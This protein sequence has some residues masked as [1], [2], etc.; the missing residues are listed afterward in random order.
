MTVDTNETFSTVF[1]K[2]IMRPQVK[3]STKLVL[4]LLLLGVL[5][6]EAAAQKSLRRK[7]AQSLN[8]GFVS[9]NTQE[10]L[11]LPDAINR[12]NSADE[13]A[14]LRRIN[15]FSCVVGTRIRTLRALG[16]WSDGAEY[17]VMLRVYSDV[18]TVRYLLS[19]VGREAHQKSVLYFHPA[20]TGGAR[21]YALRP[22]RNNSNLTNVASIM[23]RSGIAFRT[24]VPVKKTTIIFVVDL[25]GELRAK[26]LTAARKLGATVSSEKGTAEFIGDDSSA[27]K[28]QRVFDQ[29]INDFESKHPALP[30]PCDV[31][32]PAGRA[33][34]T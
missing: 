27:E 25:K 20:S 17:S 9:P 1:L 8:Y 12:I 14:L 10:N 18:P 33:T 29:E 30:S 15:S 34:S 3:S 22:R 21:I 5:S 6:P 23:E 2:R 4:F 26:I 32:E 13:R 16:S 19:R 11:Q 24:L 31:P 28:A 7:A